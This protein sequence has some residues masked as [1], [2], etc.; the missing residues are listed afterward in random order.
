MEGNEENTREAL[1]DNYKVLKGRLEKKSQEI[2]GKARALN[3]NRTVLFGDSIFTLRK[4]HKIITENNCVPVDMV[5]L[6]GKLLLGYNVYFG[7]RKIDTEDTFALYQFS[8]DTFSAVQDEEE[9]SFLREEQFLRDY[10]NLLSFNKEA[11]LIQ[12]R[13][14]SSKFLAIFQTG[15]THR[16][17]KVFRWVSDGKGTLSYKD[18]FGGDDNVF[19][20]SHDFDWIQTTPEDFV[21]GQHPHISIQNKIFVETVGGDLT[22]KVENNTEDGEGIY[23]EPV[24]D[25]Y[26]TLD[27]AKI[28]Y[29]FVG[30]LIVLQITPRA[31]DPRY[32]VFNTLTNEVVREDSIGLSCIRLPE[33]QGLIFPRGYVLSEGSFRVFSFDTHNLEFKTKL[34]SPN[35]ED[36][37]FVY[38]RR[39]DGHYLLLQYNMVNKE[40]R[41]PIECHGYSIMDD[42]TLFFFWAK[43]EPTTTHEVQIW[44]TPF[45]SDSYYADHMQTQ[46]PSFLRDIGNAEL[47][48]AISDIQTLHKLVQNPEPTSSLYKNLVRSCD[49]IVQDF[50]WLSHEEG[51]SFEADIASL[52]F[53]AGQIIDEFDKVSTQKKKAKLSLR[54]TEKVIAELLADLRPE[55]FRNISSFMEGM[56]VL[57]QQ[58]AATR[59][60]ETIKYI[61]KEE[62]QIQIGLLDEHMS[63]LCALCAKFLQKP[64]AFSSLLRSLEGMEKELTQT[65]KTKELKSINEN[66]NTVMDGLNV[67]TDAKERLQVDDIE[68]Q[69]AITQAIQGVRRRSNQVKFA[70]DNQHKKLREKE[71]VAQFSADISL[72]DSELEGGVAR[73]DSPEACDEEKSRLSGLL[74]DLDA[75]FGDVDDFVDQIDEKRELLQSTLFSKKQQLLEKRQARVSRLFSNGQ[76]IVTGLS[77]R[78]FADIGELKNFFAT[79]RRIQRVRKLA[80]QIAALLDTNKAEELLSSLQ[81]TEQDSLRKLRD[82]AELFEEGSNLIKLGAHRF[83][84]NTQPFEL[85]IAPYEE[86]VA[87]HIS[88]TDFHEP[89][90]DEEFLRT[91][92]YW[93]QSLVSENEH[94]SRSEYLAAAVMFA[95]E[96]EEHNLSLNTLEQAD[97]LAKHVEDYA[98]LSPSAGYVKGIHDEDATKILQALLRLRKDVGNLRF[99]ASSRAAG[100][101]WWISITKK[102]EQDRWK[103]RAKSF[104]QMK[105]TLGTGT[106][107][108]FSHD[109][110][111]AISTYLQSQN[112][113]QDLSDLERE[114]AGAYLS[115][116]L[117]QT[118]PRFILSAVAADMDKQIRSKI[119]KGAALRELMKDIKDLS[120]NISDQEQLARAWIKAGISSIDPKSMYVLDELVVYWCSEPN[121]WQIH[122]VH[123]EIEVQ[124]LQSQHPNIVNGTLSI[125]YDSF[126]ERLT[127]FHTVDVPGFLHY[128]QLRHEYIIAQ[129][130]RLRLNELRPRVL[131]SFVR[132]KLINEVYL[133]LIGDNLAKQIGA[134]GAGKRTDLMGMLLLISPPGYGK[135]TLMEYVASRLGMAFVKVNGPSIGHKVVSLDPSEAPNATAKQEVEKINLGFEMANNVMLYLDDIQ[136]TDPEFLQKFISLCDGQRRIE[137][138]W[139]GRTRTY[140]LRGKRF[141]VIMAG[142]PYT[143]TGDKFQIPD[144]LAN[145]ADIYNLGDQLSGKEHLFA[146]S[147]IENALTSNRVLAPLSTRPQKDVYLFSRMAQGEEVSASELSYDYSGVER[148]DIIQTIQHMMQCRDV[149]LRVNEQY[150]FAAA[151]DDSLRKEPPFKLQGSYRN[152]SKLTEKL[153]PAMNKEEVNALIS[154]HYRGESQT[155][156]SGARSNLLKLEELRGRLQGD[157]REEWSRIKEE[158][159]MVRRMGGSGDDP[160]A[161]VTGSLG[162]ISEQLKVIPMALQ[163]NESSTHIEK[164]HQQLASLQGDWSKENEHLL[165]SIND[166]VQSLQSAHDPIL[167][168]HVGKVS[169]ELAQLRQTLIKSPVS[170]SVHSISQEL[171]GMRNIDFSSI[172]SGVRTDL[173]ALQQASLSNETI[174]I[175]S[176]KEA[177]LQLKNRL[178]FETIV[179]AINNMGGTPIHS[180]P[181]S[182]QNHPVLEEER[183]QEIQGLFIHEAM[184]FL[185]DEELRQFADPTVNAA[186]SALFSITEQINM[187]LKKVTTPKVHKLLVSRLQQDLKSIDKE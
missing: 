2:F 105:R 86:G 13:L 52:R 154:D 26:Q 67:L 33:S 164:I 17:T 114:R 98:S 11:K 9:W 184:R 80:T 168:T 74:D 49:R 166:I 111:E 57:D 20:L 147:Y 162:M 18:E 46:A 173:Q 181:P 136:H 59:S 182:K 50:S 119:R 169:Q 93:N 113:M 121:L 28:A 43:D 15:S 117:S 158:F 106:D 76:Q 21:R 126:L 8:E 94:V 146:L 41:N 90:E 30:Q 65:K 89:I 40:V 72:F 6:N 70:L 103:R 144:M 150:I 3:E 137:G 183:Q 73:A 56:S 7:L 179:E 132:N 159:L 37:L 53:T 23:A 115:I 35:G 178:N 160:V 151:Q 79:D 5:Y 27:D 175:Q 100:V 63:S 29:A 133:P 152:M 148:D 138:V 34:V 186:L 130:K 123:T 38:L 44:N 157:E 78:R 104:A 120:D 176:I 141:C 83:A 143:E 88:N 69:T 4:K 131:T 165:T 153:A 95:A 108:D 99:P 97:N 62:L 167:T 22:I 172:F 92:R 140:D 45:C 47:V 66:L 12:F 171:Q 61:N 71:S 112:I 64:D 32:F 145:R 161:R 82:T 155:L 170:E 51:G 187:R 163:N 25:P 122:K 91:R 54:K 110:K 124:D 10:K 1:G 109:I 36:V 85:T 60:L 116:E 107:T 128:R 55:N 96:R 42:G 77:E 139:R 102:E 135:T 129:E 156:T 142:N 149:L 118:L 180:N 48:R 68:V 185:N 39:K 81:A 14:L 134:S 84:I 58:M 177:L 125:R 174:D 24:D 101:W 31:E 19:P 75:R 87:L 16:D 127:K